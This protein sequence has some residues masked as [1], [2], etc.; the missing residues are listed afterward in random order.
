MNENMLQ[1]S[2]QL[3]LIELKADDSNKTPTFSMTAYTGVP[4]RQ[5]F[6]DAPVIVDLAGMEIAQKIPVRLD[7]DPTQR[8]GHTTEVSISDGNIIAKG[9]ISHDNEYSRTVANSGKLGFPW[10]A[11]I[12][13]LIELKEEVPAGK[14]V[15][16]N[17]AEYTGPM[18]IARKSSLKEISFVDYGADPNTAAIVAKELN[19]MDE[20][21]VV[22]E[23]P[24]AGEVKASEP[25]KAD[26]KIEA[27]ASPVIEPAVDTASAVQAMRDAQAAELER[28]ASIRKVA[29]PGSEEL[30]AKAIREGWSADKFELTMLRNQKPQSVPAPA[31]HAEERETGFTKKVAEIVAMRSCG[32]FRSEHE[33]NYSEQELLAADKHSRCGLREYFELACGMT[34]SQHLPNARSDTK[35]WLRAAFDAT[36]LPGILSNNANKVLLQGYEAVED[37]WRDVFKVGAVS[38]FKVHTRYRMNSDFVFEKV[39]R[40]GELKHGSISEDTY[41]QK[42]DTYGIMFSLTRQMI[43]DDDL[44]ALYD[45]PFQIGLGAG[46]AISDAVWGLF[47][48]NPNSFF[49]SD[50]Q[51]LLEGADYAMGVDGLTG[52]EVYFR[53]KTAPNGRP[54]GARP[55]ILL[56][57]PELLTQAQQLM[58]AQ[59]I[60][61]TTTANK[62][63]PN[64][65]PHE[66]KYKV[67][68]SPY[69]S[70]SALTGNSATAYYL[71]AN[72]IRF[73]S[74]EIAFLGG[75]DR[76]TVERADA[77]FNTLGVQFRGYLDFGVKEQ[78]YRGILKV[79][80]VA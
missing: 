38:D 10:Q 32:L 18:L 1:L 2:G 69:L 13:A 22:D 31:I 3:E 61:E 9:L 36:S 78:D 70:S 4:I 50:N 54:L 33:K 19:K 71:L 55:E 59:Y 12:G 16:V 27:K 14:K 37:C 29:Q 67:F 25:V 8:I 58:T 40:G 48:S 17:G 5:W 72:P 47:L 43:I 74:F 20:E 64:K 34:G 49:S 57:P 75:V 30:Q 65:N 11:S 68:C 63:R 76:P 41:T 7:H 62:A 56:V 66:G 44:G 77:D 51:S 79:K 73:P 15:N 26:E 6:Y 39:P 28:V 35:E 80:G 21:K 46:Q 52:A 60:N 42:I 23:Q 45:I 53:K 24:K